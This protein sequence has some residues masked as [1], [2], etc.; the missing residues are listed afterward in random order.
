MVSF[1]PFS[2]L[3]STTAHPDAFQPL[4]FRPHIHCIHAPIQVLVL[5]SL[6]MLSYKTLV[7][8]VLAL[9]TTPAFS[10]PVSYA[11]RISTP[12][13]TLSDECYHPPR[14]NQQQAR[15]AIEE[16]PESGGS[17]FV[18]GLLKNV[19]ISAGLSVLDDAAK[20][21]F[22][23]RTRRDTELTLPTLHFFPVSNNGDLNASPTPQGSP[24]RF[25][26]GAPGLEEAMKGP[27]S[28]DHSQ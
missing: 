2:P 23:N 12:R 18:P 26:Q 9:S 20:H 17:D 21:F 16:E 15:A 28:L 1:Q 22:G 25:E 10:A 8:V 11:L 4:R 13:A 19:G 5:L 6:N 14:N 7:V 3:L 27:R 24:V